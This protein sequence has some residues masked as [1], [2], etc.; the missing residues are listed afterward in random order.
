[1]DAHRQALDECLGQERAGEAD[2]ADQQ[3]ERDDLGVI[4]PA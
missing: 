4:T 1:M 2:D 3:A